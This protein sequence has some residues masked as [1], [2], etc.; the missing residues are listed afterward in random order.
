M[1]KLSRILL[2]VATVWPLLYLFGFTAMMFTSTAFF[3]TSKQAGSHASELFI[4]QHFAIF[5]GLHLFTMLIT[6]A[7]IATYIIHLFK[8]SAVPQDK[9][10]LWAVVL[11][12]GNAFAMPVYWYLYVFRSGTVSP[13]SG[14]G[15]PS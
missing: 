3:D 1:S 11:F 10:V 9:K 13:R 14:V 7:L 15:G 12:L 5:M 8:T 2:G 4:F 6:V